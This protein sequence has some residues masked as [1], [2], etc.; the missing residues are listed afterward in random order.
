MQK[1]TIYHTE[2]KIPVVPVGRGSS[3]VEMHCIIGDN[4]SCSDFIG[5][6]IES[7]FIF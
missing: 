2:F 7:Y 1:I 6:W 4:K 3:I 5:K